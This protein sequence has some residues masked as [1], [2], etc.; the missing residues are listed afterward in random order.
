MNAALRPRQQLLYSFWLHIRKHPP[1][2]DLECCQRVTMI[3]LDLDMNL[4]SPPPTP[5]HMHGPV[6]T[7]KPRLPQ[8]VQPHEGTPARGCSQWP[9][10]QSGGQSQGQQQEQRQR[11]REPAH[12]HLWAA[13]AGAGAA[14]MAGGAAA[15]CPHAPVGL[16]A[17]RVGGQGQLPTAAKARACMVGPSACTAPSGPL[18]VG[19]CQPRAAACSVA[20]QMHATMPCSAL[21]TLSGLVHPAMPT[22]A[23]QR[24]THLARAC[25]H[26]PHTPSLTYPPT[27]HPA[28]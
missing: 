26:T 4:T 5:M 17:C 20:A 11:Q 9:R 22:R 3:A 10:C 16:H 1:A 8:P 28:G 21:V 24:P 27:P 19:C 23:H 7:I 14:A 12:H 25:A 15:C 6:A 18:P 13:A 2:R